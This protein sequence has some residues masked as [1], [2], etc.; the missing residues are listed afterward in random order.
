MYHHLTQVPDP[1]SAFR[2][3]EAWWWG[4]LCLLY[5][6]IMSDVPEH[7]AALSKDGKE[8]KDSGDYS[9]YLKS[10]AHLLQPTE[11]NPLPTAVPPP[12]SALAGTLG[13]R[14]VLCFI[15]LPERGK[16]FLAHRMSEYL[17]F[18]H[19]ASVK[20]FDLTQYAAATGAPAG[21]EENADAVLRDLKAF[22]SSSPAAGRNMDACSGKMRTSSLSE[23]SLSDAVDEVEPVVVAQDSMRQQAVDSGRVALIYATD[24][25]ASFGELWSGTSKERRRWAYDKLQVCTTGHP[26]VSSATPV[27]APRRP[28]YAF[29][30]AAAN[31]CRPRLCRRTNRCR[32]SS[33]SS[34]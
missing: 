16:P 17:S 13:A 30:P 12:T 15:G 6:L 10:Q 29:A 31:P 24:T 1:L 25:F 2:N 18:F 3:Y 22:M 19:G 27:L 23:P 11:D 33:S 8:R 4:I 9:P 7:P 34:K 28:H 5:R 21:S 26:G 14:H 20:R 32:S